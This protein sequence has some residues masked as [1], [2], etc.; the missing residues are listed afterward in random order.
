MST[1][2]KE[3][4]EEEEDGDKQQEEGRDDFERGSGLIW[5]IF[6]M[7]LFQ[8]RENVPLGPS[9]FRLIIIRTDVKLNLQLKLNNI[10]GASLCHLHGGKTQFSIRFCS[11]SKLYEEKTV[12]GQYC[13]Q[14]NILCNI[15]F[16][17]TVAAG[18]TLL[19]QVHVCVYACV[20]GVG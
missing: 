7:V 19:L 13:L 12:T 3:S 20:C 8:L 18:K 4:K 9:Q 17:Q 16:L 11:F 14:G 15:L 1:E 6:L 2:L 5:L 10:E